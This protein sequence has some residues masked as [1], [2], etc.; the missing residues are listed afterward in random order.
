MFDTPAVVEA[1]WNAL[2]P[3]GYFWA[4]EYTGPNHAQYTPE[5]IERASVIRRMFPRKYT[6]PREGFPRVLIPVA[7]KRPYGR[8]PSEGVDSERI[9][10]TIARVMPNA[11]IWPLG[12]IAYLI[13]FAPMCARFD[14]KSEEDEEW[15]RA[16]MVIDDQLSAKGLNL[17][18][19]IL[20]EKR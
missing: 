2:N 7:S 13:A 10:P 15:I 14:P 16:M 20:A 8:D 18:H 11:E 3:G 1:S 9:M 17:K 5:M 19:A 6:G 4:V 12:G